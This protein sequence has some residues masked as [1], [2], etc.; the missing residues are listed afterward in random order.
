MRRLCLLLALFFFLAGGVGAELLP[1]PIRVDQREEDGRHSLTLHNKW[2]VPVT[3]RMTFELENA[4]LNTPNPVT[5]VVPP[6]GTL[7]GPVITR[8]NDRNSWDWS[9]ISYFHYGDKNRLAADAPF[10]LPF[11]KGTRFQV[12]QGF[13]GD[14]SHKG[15]EAY[16]VDFDLPE[17]TEVRAARDGFVVK[18]VEEYTAGGWDLALKE[19]ANTVI[20]VHSDGT[21]SRYVH[22][23]HNSVPVSPGEWVKSGD[24]LGL[25][26]NTGYSTGPHLHF[27]VYTPGEDLR[28]RTVKFEFET[29]GRRF[30]P[31]EGEFY[32]N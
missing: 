16:A 4:L 15:V 12:L 8:K 9:Y 27:D 18:V 11:N 2:P 20:L 21:S 6:K 3:F 19:R 5:Y 10:A 29:N 17:G 31:V 24:L 25:S 1:D 13:H 7:R 28:V 14:L 32:K 30:T 22:L 23:Q 26:G